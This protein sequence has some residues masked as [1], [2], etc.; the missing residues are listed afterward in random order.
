M[1]LI[2][3]MTEK[4]EVRYTIGVLTYGYSFTFNYDSGVN[5]NVNTLV[6]NSQELPWSVGL[7]RVKESVPLHENLPF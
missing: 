1:P 6:Q 7:C 2:L 5:Q 4:E 3:L